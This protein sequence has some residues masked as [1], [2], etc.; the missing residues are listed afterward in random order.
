MFLSLIHIL[1][2]LVSGTLGWQSLNQQA[3]NEAQ[4][5]NAEYAHVELLKLEKLPD[6]TKTQNPVPG[7]AFFL[8]TEG[9]E[10]L[11][12]R[13]VTDSDGKI[14]VRL[15]PGE[16]YF[17]EIFPSTGFSFDK[18]ADGTA[19]SRYPLT[20]TGEETEPCLLYTS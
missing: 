2:S 11:G 3:K 15:E 10:Q 5:D 20:V 9:G 1:S 19:I 4:S 13:Y 7:A 17:E 18:G 12:G 16:Y 8:F 6:G 14:S